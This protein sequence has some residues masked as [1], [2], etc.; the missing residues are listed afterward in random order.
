MNNLVTLSSVFV[1]KYFITNKNGEPIGLCTDDPD[2]PHIAIV[3]N[4]VWFTY[5]ESVGWR[6][7]N[8]LN[9][10]RLQQEYYLAQITSIGGIKL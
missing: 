7:V 5:T 3:P 6:I 4:S 1:G 8:R 9:E 2:I 10:G